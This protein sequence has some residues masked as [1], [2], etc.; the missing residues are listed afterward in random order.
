MFFFCCVVIV[1]GV[2]PAAC[3]PDWLTD[4]VPSKC[5][6]LRRVF[7]FCWCVVVRVFRLLIRLIFCSQ[8]RFSFRFERVTNSSTHKIRQFLRHISAPRS[9]ANCSFYLLW[10]FFS[11]IRKKKNLV[12]IQFKSIVKTRTFC[13]LCE[14]CA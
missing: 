4:C 10:F 11:I 2:K 5:D 13:T 3:L 8:A 1:V 14:Y 6:V 12:L 7:V 9:C